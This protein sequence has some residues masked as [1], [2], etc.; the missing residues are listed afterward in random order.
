MGRSVHLVGKIERW[1]AM[2]DSLFDFDSTWQEV[3]QARYLSWPLAQRYKYCE[4]RDRDAA[5]HAENYHEATWHIERADS[6]ARLAEI[7]R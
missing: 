5:E 2:T 6:Y 1:T 4:E 3:P 7:V